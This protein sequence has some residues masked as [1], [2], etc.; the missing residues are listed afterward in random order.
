M[1]RAVGSDL[2]AGAVRVGVRDARKPVIS[3]SGRPQRLVKEGS[4]CDECVQFNRAGQ[5]E[6]AHEKT[7]LGGAA[8]PQFH[9]YLTRALAVVRLIL[10]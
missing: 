10:K 4:R 3:R 1:A 6:G 8:A 7:I 9:E 2:V 5:D